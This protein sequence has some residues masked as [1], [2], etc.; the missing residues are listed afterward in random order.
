M[1][2][3]KGRICRVAFCL[4]LEASALMGAPVRPD[5]VEELMQALRQPKVAHVLPDEPDNGKPLT[6]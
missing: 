1:K 6:D 2:F 3:F 5:E 4:I